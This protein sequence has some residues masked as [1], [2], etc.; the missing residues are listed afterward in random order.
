M[1]I[2]IQFYTFTDDG[3]ERCS[4]LCGTRAVIYTKLSKLSNISSSPTTV[5]QTVGKKKNPANHH[6]FFRKN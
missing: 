3:S 5:S 2:T 4:D 1:C 6:G